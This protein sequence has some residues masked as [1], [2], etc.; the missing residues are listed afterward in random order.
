MRIG[1]V[2]PCL[3]G[4]RYLAEALESI[5][6]QT[7]PPD[8]VVLVDN[9][10]TDRSAQIARDHGVRVVRTPTPRG[11]AGDARDFGIAALDTPVLAFLDADDRWAPTKLE[12]Q[13]ALLEGDPAV[14]AV[15]GG[16]RQFLSED[17]PDLSGRVGFGP[18]VEV[19]YLFSALLIRRE[20]YARAG[21]G[22]GSFGLGE[23]I[24]FFRRARAVLRIEAVPEIVAARRV[25]GDNST[26]SDPARLHA[27]YLR[28][29][30]QAILDSRQRT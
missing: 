18:D 10:S 5:A 9:G 24:D 19:G 2:V 8:D 26:L 28:A 23:T 1:V 11:G 17:R 27:D 16:I 29:A 3:N 21:A 20:A 25:H 30:R 22:G 7:R 13:A 15:V 4:E 12:R 14:D 6:A